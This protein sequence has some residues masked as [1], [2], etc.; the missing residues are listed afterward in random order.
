MSKKNLI[1]IGCFVGV[2]GIKGEVKLKSFTEIPENIFSFREI[3]TET[4]ENPIKLKLIRKLKQ[5]FVCKIENVETRSDAEF[6][7]GLKLFISRKSL[8]KLID[9]EFY[10]SD[11]LN[12]KV[13]NLS[14]ENF[15]EVISLEDFGA[16]LLVQVKKNNKTFYLPMGK[17]FLKKI[18][19]KN[20][21]IILELDLDFIKN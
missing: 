7:K 13:Y 14:K 11:L 15:G 6:Y 4:S 21:Q 10:H 19:Y 12:F 9:G 16:G 20:R 8:P 5:T 18:D 2:H 1:E 17:T 3:F